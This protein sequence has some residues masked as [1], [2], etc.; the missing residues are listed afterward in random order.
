M[1]ILKENSGLKFWRS[2]VDKKI[3]RKKIVEADRRM[4]ADVL[5]VLIGRSEVVSHQKNEGEVVRM[6]ILVKKENLEKVLEFMKANTGN[7][8]VISSISSSLYLEERINAMKRR[9]ISRAN[10]VKSSWQASFS[11]RPALH[12]IPE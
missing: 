4:D 9:R 11:W 8:S 7:S 5:S 6:K 10:A 2:R 3:S 1:E 12:S